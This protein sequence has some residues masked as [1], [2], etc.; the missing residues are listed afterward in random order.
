MTVYFGEVPEFG[1]HVI[2]ALKEQLSARMNRTWSEIKV[3]MGMVGYDFGGIDMQ[4]LAGVKYLD[5]DR[6][7]EGSVPLEG[8]QDLTFAIDVGLEETTFLVSFNKDIGRSWT[9]S[10]FLGANGAKSSLTANFGYRW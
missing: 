10:S 4:A 6:T 3:W 2:T 1:G 7:L 8:G 5:T 9:L